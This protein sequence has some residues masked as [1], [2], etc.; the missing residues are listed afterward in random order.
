MDSPLMLSEDPI[1]GGIVYD[2]GGK[3]TLSEAIGIGV[4]VSEAYLK[5]LEHCM[6]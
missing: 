5:T 1:Q 6:I 4:D 3:I 2:K